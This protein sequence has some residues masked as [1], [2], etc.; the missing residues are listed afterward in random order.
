MKK[1]ILIISPHP[2][3]LGGVANH[4]IGLND[5]WSSSIKY[6]YCGKRENIPAFVTFFYDLI[7]YVLKL[8]FKRP[9]IV[10]INP[11]LRRYQIM[12]DGLYL[13]LAKI[14]RIDVITFIHGW[15]EEYVRKLI[16]KPSLFK[17]V[18][19][20]SAFIYVLSSSFKEQLL[21]VGITCPILLTTTKV[22]DKLIKDF[23]IDQR[24]GKINNILF[25][26]RIE[27]EKGV[28]ITINAFIILKAKYDWLTLTIVG[29]G[30]FL[31]EA[32][33]YVSKKNI[34]DVS[35]TGPLYGMDV[36]KEFSKSEIYILPTTHGEGMPTSVLEA[37][38]F[39]LPIITRPVGG[40]NDFF[41]TKEMGSLI[42][43]LSPD[44]F[45]RELESFILSSEKTR[46]TALF[47][48]NYSV[49]RF[50]ASSVANKIEEDIK[51]Y[52]K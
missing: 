42:E 12:R 23:D 33:E 36:A 51:D 27:R 41:D 19:N 5:F 46:K 47:N 44:S 4:Y 10:I 3:L 37:M 8:I 49:N 32:K 15:D 43:D 45:A 1:N 48:H 20:K 50:L 38:V 26:A 18:Y 28:L 9:D 40:L 52:L 35:F 6:E 30:G 13:I 22:D 34:N 29:S 11:S 21:E 17:F 24:T 39:G 2:K 14:L 16:K 25:L 31:N 7:K